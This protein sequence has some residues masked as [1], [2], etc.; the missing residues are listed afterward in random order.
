M[1]TVTICSDEMVKLYKYIHYIYIL[2]I[3]SAIYIK[4]QWLL[5]GKALMPLFELESFLSSNTNLIGRMTDRK[6]MVNKTQI[7]VYIFL[8]MS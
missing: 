3:Y 7:F 5:G 6:T 4:V 8:K 2:D 1:A